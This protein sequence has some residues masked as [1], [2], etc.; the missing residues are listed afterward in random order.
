MRKL[1][2]QIEQNEDNKN[3]MGLFS[4]FYTSGAEKDM[5]NIEDFYDSKQSGL[6]NRFSS[7][8]KRDLEKLKR[9]PQM[10]AKFL[11][12]V[13]RGHVKKFPYSFY[14]KENMSK[15]VITLLAVMAQARDPEQIAQIL[16]KRMDELG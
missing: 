10:Y 14:Y 11:D 2:G 4:I 7:N 3:N 8:L 16:E 13:R 1:F 9:N 5:D 12:G 15:E 6:G